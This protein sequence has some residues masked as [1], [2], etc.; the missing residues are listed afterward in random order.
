[1]E[2]LPGTASRS[3]VERGDVDVVM[4]SWHSNYREVYDK[5]IASGNMVDLGPNYP[6]GP[7]GWYIP[8][9]LVE[10]ADA[11]ASAKV[12][13]SGLQLWGIYFATLPYLSMQQTGVIYGGVAGW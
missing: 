5:A 12:G 6:D 2:I 7:Q 1:M 10:G 3:I 8:R 13:N 11:P 9:F 4:E